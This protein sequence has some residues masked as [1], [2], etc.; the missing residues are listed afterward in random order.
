MLTSDERAVVEKLTEAF[1]MF[2]NLPVLQD[3]DYTD[4]E[5]LTRD[6]QTL[7]LSRAGM[8][9]LGFVADGH[10]NGDEVIVADGLRTYPAAVRR[11]GS[12]FVTA[13]DLG[14]GD[15]KTVL[16]VT[17]NFT[18]ASPHWTAIDFD[19]LGIEG[20]IQDTSIPDFEKDAL[21]ITTDK[22]KWFVED[23]YSK[24][25]ARK[26][27]P[28]DADPH[29]THLSAWEKLNLSTL[30]IDG[31]VLTIE[32]GGHGLDTLLVTT[33]RGQWLVDDLF[34]KPTASRTNIPEGLTIDPY[35][36]IGRSDLVSIGIEGDVIDVQR[37]QTFE[38]VLYI[39]TTEGK[40]EITIHRRAPMQVEKV[41]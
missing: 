22:G 9:D 6:A 21:F 2:K 41:E 27:A 13:A 25:T 19:T 30:P 32:P 23:V 33:D 29:E 26:L 36:W 3:S 39:K 37:D 11:G 14:K 16:Q 17:D 38:H 28:Q 8:R 10:V 1:F 34:G 18:D 40:W 31:K 24:P 5:K 15:S 20:V 12:A 35:S 7:V 4:F